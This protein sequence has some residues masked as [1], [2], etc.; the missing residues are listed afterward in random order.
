MKKK[1]EKRICWSC[2]AEVSLHLQSCPYCG[3]DFAELKKKNHEKMPSPSVGASS[4]SLPS[5]KEWE[6][7]LEFV[8]DQE[9]RADRHKNE[10]VALLIFFS[11]VIL[12]LMGLVIFLFSKEG[13]LTLQW[14][15]RHALFFLISSLP[16]TYLGWRLL[17]SKNGRM[18]QK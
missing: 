8:A 7:A 14:N 6:Q 12:F 11:G 1:N 10:F 16:C 9:I 18:G 15:M 13:V 17:L 3:Q 2:D 4:I 5:N